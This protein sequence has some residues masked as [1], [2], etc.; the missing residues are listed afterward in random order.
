MVFST[1]NNMPGLTLQQLQ[2]QGAKPV[3]TGGLSLSELQ[4]QGAKPVDPYASM[5]APQPKKPLYDK[6][7]NFFGLSKAADTLGSNIAIASNALNPFLSLEEKIT[8]NDFLKQPTLKENIGAGLS[9]GSTVASLGTPGA[10][11][12]ARSALQFGTLSASAAAGDALSDNA[13]LENT[14][15][16]AFKGGLTGAAL[17][18]GV[19]VATNAIGS[20]VSKGPEAIYNNSLRV[21]NRMKDAGKSPAEFLKDEGVW[22]SLGT[23]KKA[24]AEGI[25]KESAAIKSKLP[26]AGGT[27]WGTV[28]ERAFK[29][30]EKSLGELYS[31]PQLEQL[32]NDV[33]V[34]SLQSSADDV[35]WEKLD[36]TRQAL[37]KY[38]G[39][40]KW[41]A[42]NSSEKIKAAKAV[43]G[44]MSE[45]EKA[46]TGATEEF[47]RLSQW[48]NTEKVVN[49]AI[50]IADN[51]YGLGLYDFV[52]GTGGAAIG[53]LTSDGSIGDRLTNAATGA[54]IG[55]GL[56]RSLT[57]PALK[58]G[59]AQ[60]LTK[61]E[62]IPTDAAGRVSKAAITQLIGRLTQTT[63]ETPQT[64]PT[65][66]PV[67]NLPSS[68]S[69]TG[70]VSVNGTNLTFKGPFSGKE[71]TVDP[72]GIGGT[73][74]LAKGLGPV[75]KNAIAQVQPSQYERIGE[76]LVR[77]DKA[78]KNGN[79]LT[80]DS[81]LDTYQSLFQKLGL[82]KLGQD[83]L[84]AVLNRIMET[85]D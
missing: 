76:F 33:P 5:A 61:L 75:L 4:Q 15:R 23:F 58:T 52:S 57:S 66:Q 74:K 67:S 84:T 68:D 8:R 71:I 24:A 59:I 6:I 34:S 60:L 37:G 9:L 31:K 82:D 18:A 17:G 10:G 27:N 49:R 56:E 43:Y 20:L 50:G 85:A 55:I 44:A 39:D 7:T 38:I 3:S 25:A 79:I 32:I 46:A 73:V 14:A 2:A 42:A 26:A 80:Q 47:H 19:K 12:V 41:L 36:S 22:G 78:I 45:L 21:L 54:A 64:L 13:S 51:R 29:K 35:P 48:L 40:N 1:K 63:E 62:S 30:L 53:G 69:T 72:T 83:D 65:E 28:Q 81:L 77:W 11:T 16:S 70:D